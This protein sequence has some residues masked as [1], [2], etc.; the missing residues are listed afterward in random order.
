MQSCLTFGGATS[1]A[2]DMSSI[3]QLF[4]TK[5]YRTLLRG[6]GV[7]KLNE[8]LARAIEV[9][10]ADDEAGLAWSRANAYRGYTSYASLSDLTWRL[11]EF[12]D[13]RQRIDPHVAAFADDL[14]LELGDGALELDSI[15]AN[16]L[17]PGG[18]HAAHIHPHSVISGT[19]YVDVPD[20]AGAIRFEDPRL[21]M[22]MAAPTRKARARAENRTFVSVA[23]KAGTLLLWESWL[24]HEVRPGSA[25]EPRISISFNYSWGA[26]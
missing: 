24:R 7:R 22:M 13:L 5:I 16:V 25:D 8:D 11:P 9:L 18:T 2:R 12:D 3:E 19:Y 23:P 4:V 1:Y 15:W 20:G 26:A 6:K 21:A 14:D 17:E 10:A